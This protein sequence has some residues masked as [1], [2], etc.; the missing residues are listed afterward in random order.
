MNGMA[1]SI[2]IEVETAMEQVYHQGTNV[3]SQPNYQGI[4]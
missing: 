2:G 3:V 1:S 4:M